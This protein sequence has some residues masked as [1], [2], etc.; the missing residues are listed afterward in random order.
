[1]FKT[2]Y[3]NKAQLVS[4]IISSFLDVSRREDK[5]RAVYFETWLCEV[6]MELLWDQHM[7]W[8]ANLLLTSD[9]A[10]VVQGRFR[11]KISPSSRDYRRTEAPHAYMYG[12]AP[13]FWTILIDNLPTASPSEERR[14]LSFGEDTSTPAFYQLRQFVGSF[15]LR[16]H[17]K[18]QIQQLQLKP[19]QLSIHMHSLVP[20]DNQSLRWK[21]LFSLVLRVCGWQIDLDCILLQFSYFTSC[22]GFWKQLC[23]IYLRVIWIK[24]SSYQ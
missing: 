24:K 7:K 20:N 14:T 22:L 11:A 18:K 1:M 15:A 16:L 9:P 21:F 17:S 3:D 8:C 12:N 10:L 4:I 6:C 5:T 23:C 19:F 2:S 13:R